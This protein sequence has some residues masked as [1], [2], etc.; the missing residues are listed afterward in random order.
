MPDYDSRRSDPYP[1]P[2]AAEIAA[3]PGDA[4]IRAARNIIV[5]NVQGIPRRGYL[6]GHNDKAPVVQAVAEFVSAVDKLLMAIPS[7]DYNGTVKEAGDLLVTMMNDDGS[8]KQP[9]PPASND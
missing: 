7:A 8:A 9:S 3:A 1:H 2:T 5:R 4:I 6:L